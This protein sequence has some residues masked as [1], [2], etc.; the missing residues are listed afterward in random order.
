M[1]LHEHMCSITL[2]DHALD[3][4]APSISPLTNKSTET[5]SV[6][7]IYSEKYGIYALCTLFIVVWWVYVYIVCQHVKSSCLLIC[8]YVNKHF[9]FLCFPPVR[10][11]GWGGHTLLHRARCRP[12]LT[13]S[14]PW[15]GNRTPTSLSCSH[16]WWREGGWDYYSICTVDHKL[17]SFHVVNLCEKYFCV[18]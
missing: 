2:I 11:T 12:P 16:S 13:T 8:C 17:G 9:V 18:E 7:A 3:Y 6:G 4:V 1:I 10:V 14:G 5:N 15:S